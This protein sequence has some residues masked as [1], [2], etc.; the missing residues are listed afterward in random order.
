MKGTHVSATQE[1][2]S[3]DEENNLGH[4]PEN[5]H[6]KRVAVETAQW[7]VLE[8]TSGHIW[9]PTLLRGLVKGSRTAFPTL[10]PFP[11]HPREGSEGRAEKHLVLQ[12]NSASDEGLAGLRY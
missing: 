12:G 3:P 4:N 6:Q 1:S 8:V 2:L 9:P 5:V 11:H 10:W 7:L